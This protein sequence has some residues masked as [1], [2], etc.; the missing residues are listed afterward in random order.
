MEMGMT[1]ELMYG[2]NVF[3]PA[4]A[5]PYQY[6]YA[7]VGSPMEWYNHPSSL[8][9][10]GQDI[11]YPADGMPCVYYAAPDNGSM[12]PSYS[13]YL[14][15]PSFVPDGSFMPQEYFSDPANST[16]Q[17]APTP[18]YIPALPFAQDSV[19]GSATAPLHS[20][21][22]FLHG[23]PGY[24]A[25]SANAAFPLI[26]PVTTKSDMA[27]NLPVQCSIVSSK[28]FQ[29]QAK[30]PKAQLHNSVAP[31]QELPDRS[32]VPIKLPH[33][34]QASAHLLERPISAAKHS[35]K[36][37]LSGNNC[38]GYAA[39]DLQKW[40]AAEKFQ[41]SS[42]SSAHL[43]GPGQKV[44]LLNEHSLGHSEKSSNERSSAIVVTSYTSRLPVG[45]PEGTILIRT[46]HYNRDDLRLDYTYAKFFVIKS[47]GE[48]D[49]HKSIKYGVWSSSFNGNSKLDSAFRDADRILRRN[50]TKC[51][52]FLFFSVSVYLPNIRLSSRSVAMS[53]LQIPYI[54]GM[55]VLKI[56]KDIKVKECL[57]DDFMRYESE[58]AQN[59]PHRRR[60]LSYNAPDFVPV[61]QCTKDAS[62]T[63]QTKSSSVLIDR[64]SEIQNVSEKPH[65]P[66]VTKPQETCVEN[67]EK[68]VAETGKENGQQEN[69]C[70]GNQSHR[71]ATK[72]VTSQPPASS[73]K[74]DVDGKQ[75]Y[76]KKVEN[77]RQHAAQGSSK[78]P[79]KR[80]NGARSSSGAVS[81]SS[82]E[83]KISAKLGLL[84]ITSKTVEADRKSS[85]VGVVT[86]GSM[87]VRV[88]SS[89]V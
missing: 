24:A 31:K 61:S 51:P 40:A 74:T 19:P 22:A 36:A 57:F 20:N 41:P 6:G 39:S 42:K 72:T 50:S 28:Q 33:A 89:E 62:D 10:D 34:S 75:Q 35:A 4:T 76:W 88:D 47:I 43:N 13:P 79:E 54:P 45:D 7:E 26:A 58:E 11:F 21:V 9:Y 25:T 73:L 53:H 83:Q 38:L 63:Q 77:P 67:S 86:I 64:T 37:Q 49:V 17:I 32:M 56:F 27:V 85:T 3:V 2:Q 5:N 29:D 30:P 14:V 84:K 80:L 12:H 71:D 44:H 78:P 55:S 60:K 68:Q 81:E 82:E 69:H 46:D 15:D 23:I 87:A 65:D 48:A 59:K 52:V 18:Y 1:P 66:K 8:G 70:S 16:G